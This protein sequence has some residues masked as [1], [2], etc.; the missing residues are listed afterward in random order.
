MLFVIDGKE[1]YALPRSQ[2]TYL[3]PVVLTFFVLVV[4]SVLCA[5]VSPADA[6]L[7]VSDTA[8]DTV[9]GQANFTSGTANRGTGVEKNTLSSPVYVAFDSYGRMFVAEEGNNRILIFDSPLFDQVADTVIGQA[10][11]TS[12]SANRGFGADSNTLNAPRS[13]A[14]DAQ[15]RLFVADL[16]NHRV[17]IFDSPAND[18]SADT[19]I[20]QT[21]FSGSSE[22]A[23]TR[24]LAKPAGM[25]FDAQG[26]LYVCE[27]DS[28]RIVI[29][30][31]PANDAVA[32]T[33]IGQANFASGTANNGSGT[34]SPVRNGFY[35]PEEI[36]FDSV[37]RLYVADRQNNRV[38]IFDTPAN[39][40]V[41]DTVIGQAG[42]FTTQTAG[43]TKSTFDNP[44]GIAIDAYGRLYVSELNNNRIFVFD[45]PANDAAADSVFGQPGFTTLTSGTDANHLKVPRGMAFDTTGNFYVADQSN[46]RVLAFDIYAAP[47]S[48]AR[49]YSLS[50]T[51]GNHQ[52][53]TVSTSLD[54]L[55][56][57]TAVNGTSTVSETI[58]FSIVTTPSGST[59]A[60]LDTT[61]VSTTASGTAAVRLTLGNKNGI[62]QVA[63][64]IDTFV[65][66]FTVYTDVID[67]T[68]GKWIMFG[69]NKNP[70]TSTRAGVIEDDGFGSVDTTS[71]T[72]TSGYRLF[73]WDPTATFGD[74]YSYFVTPATIDTGKSYWFKSAGSGTNGTLDVDG[75]AVTGTAT[76]QLASGW[77]MVANPFTYFID[78]DSDVRFESTAGSYRTPSQAQ[79]D[80][81]A[82]GTAFWY[83]ASAT[84]FKWGPRSTSVSGTTAVS[85]TL[86][87]KP[88]V[89][90]QVYAQRSCTMWFYPNP[91]TPTTST[92]I[93]QA[94]R[95][96]A[97]NRESANGNGG[98][99]FWAGL[100]SFF[101]GGGST[102]W[103]MQLGVAGDVDNFVGVRSAG[104][105]AVRN[106][107]GVPQGG[108]DLSVAPYGGG[109]S[110]ALY[111]SSA[112]SSA[113]WDVSSYSSTAG[114][115]TISAAAVT[116]LPVSVSAIYLRDE[117]T[118]AVMNL[119]SASSYTYAAAAGETRKFTLSALSSGLPSSSSSVKVVYPKACLIEH[120]AGC[121][122]PMTALC[123]SIRDWMLDL[124]VGR[125]LVRGYYIYMERRTP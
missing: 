1:I 32:D 68:A 120:L 28:H 19:V 92:V 21:T 51:S 63:A 17:L 61:I 110:Y 46:H 57:V 99:G 12:S 95:Y 23:T 119:M 26:R 66:T 86:Q 117:S 90:Y 81:V 76:I 55:L 112:P 27:V 13:L 53:G 72:L 73:R 75:I 6:V 50:V 36:A 4:A 74:T 3:P 82:D 103:E 102:D 115:V 11:F 108:P 124:P 33:V 78:F 58:T 54:T 93:N 44:I 47:S 116:S 77:N 65:D 105:Y 106:A 91:R 69:P 79:T 67:I 71:A 5:M 122:S 40:G 114:N 37:G 2:L 109:G 24:G 22:A 94:P 14:F 41:A 104:T 96:L 35:T 107:P 83:D 39:D 10:N 111:Y 125:T 31:T 98:S 30:D 16:G 84:T 38:L 49:L 20:G 7:P 60:S 64:V 88:F 70:F 101:S 15:G 18:G 48:T 97:G 113:I 85:T 87:L 8:A 34:S 43:T 59:G 118:G 9:F 29:F 52:R 89:G 56:Q 45:T 80:S 62:Y 42:S 121:G 100:S 25:A 123:R